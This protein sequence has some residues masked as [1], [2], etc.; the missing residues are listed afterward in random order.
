M[1]EPIKPPRLAAAIAERLQALIL[2]GVLRPGDRLA[3][4]RELAER[5]EVSRPSLREG[6]ALLEEKRALRD[7][8]GPHGGARIV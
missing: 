6:I 5:L 4:E 8:L 7:T 2:E 3:P 1:T